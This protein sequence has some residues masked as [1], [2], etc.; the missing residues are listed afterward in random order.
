MPDIVIHPT[1]KTRLER[2]TGHPSH[3]VLLVGPVGIGKTSVAQQLVADITKV[4]IDDVTQ[5]PYIRLLRNDEKAK[6]I[7]IDAVR[8]LG[9]FLSLK[10]PGNQ[11]RVI[12]IEDAHELT[13]EAQN[14]LLKTLE[15][16]VANTTLILTVSS[17]Q[18]LLP[19]IR[20]RTVVIPIVKPAA[21]ELTAYFQRQGHNDDAIRQ[22][23]LMSG[24]LPGL[25][26]ALL[27]DDTEHPLL[28][29]TVTAREIIQKTPFERLVMVD[30]LTK[31]REH[32]L[33]T[34]TMLQQMAQVSLARGTVSKTWQRILQQSYQATELLSASAQPKL[35][36]TNL[37][38][39]L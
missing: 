21:K 33:N 13:G 3:A 29:A 38:L 2:L 7:S 11:P 12:V 39:S 34:L 16:P 4:P 20:S 36:L 35:V 9:R 25:M 23:E 26:S 31:D 37:M 15:E 24:G 10:I 27:E 19:T 6:S 1:T 17:E 8:E 30:Q 14:A 32:C 28:Q 18:S 5:H 22:A